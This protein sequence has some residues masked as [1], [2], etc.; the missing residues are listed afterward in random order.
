M[1]AIVWMTHSL[2]NWLKDPRVSA[3]DRQLAG[4]M[5][6]FYIE[7]YRAMLREHDPE[8]V[9]YTIGSKID[10]V[11][12]ASRKKSPHGNQIRCTKGCNHCCKQVVAITLPEAQLLMRVIAEDAVA[13]PLER[14]DRQAKHDDDTWQSQP[15]EDRACVFLARDG[16]CK[17]Y[18][19]RPGSCR[20]HFVI[21][22]PD[23]CDIQKHPGHR[24]GM[25]FSAEAEIMQS[26]Q[27]TA[28][29]SGPMPRMLLRAAQLQEAKQ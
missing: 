8:S 22:D 4:Q 5:T 11:V 26:A 23:L 3:H 20:K 27:M 6:E 29:E 2:K 12:A 10:E 19:Y 1:K 24:V 25:F 7:Q 21:T 9:A 14:I 15:E 18:E 17:V 13:V 16:T 28:S